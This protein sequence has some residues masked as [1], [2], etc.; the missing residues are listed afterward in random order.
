MLHFVLPQVGVF[1]GLS[2]VVWENDNLRVS[3]FGDRLLDVH[4]A[5]HRAAVGEIVVGLLLHFFGGVAGF[6]V[7]LKDHRLVVIQKDAVLKERLNKPPVF[8]LIW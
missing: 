4:V 2:G 7:S 5:F 3:S 1:P 8:W 6:C